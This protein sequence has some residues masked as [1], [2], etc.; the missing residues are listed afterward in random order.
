M[1]IEVGAI[2]T[3]RVKGHALEHT[4][5]TGGVIV[6]TVTGGIMRNTLEKIHYMYFL[7]LKIGIPVERVIVNTHGAE[8]QTTP[9][10]Q[11]I[12]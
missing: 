9:G 2:V 11:Q 12:Y 6:V 10:K 8:T 1:S 7:C 3:V 4:T 5:V